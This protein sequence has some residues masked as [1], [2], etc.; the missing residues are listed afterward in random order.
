[1]IKVMQVVGKKGSPSYL[2][3]GRYV[4]EVL[5]GE[6][7]LISFSKKGKLIIYKNS[8]L[9]WVT[10]NTEEL[11]ECYDIKKVSFTRTY[12][13]RANHKFYS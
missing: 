1:M 7:K 11:E 6:S 2:A 4:T 8:T 3:N 13:D 10:V 9:G 12:A 5:E